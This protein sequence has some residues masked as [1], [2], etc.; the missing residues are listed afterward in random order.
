MCLK[1]LKHLNGLAIH[2]MFLHP[3]RL[4]YS[5]LRMCVLAYGNSL[6][7][8]DKPLGQCDNG[9]RK[10]VGLQNIR[11]LRLHILICEMIYNPIF[12]SVILLA[13]EYLSR[14]TVF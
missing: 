1:L 2:L 9:I 8:G 11:I 4:L 5:E 10:F 14:K 7:I 3:F 6:T 12:V 13:E